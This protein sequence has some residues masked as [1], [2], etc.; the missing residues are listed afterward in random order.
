[1][2]ALL[3]E[4][5]LQLCQQPTTSVS[6][7]D[8]AFAV[9][10]YQYE[11]NA[12]YHRYCSLLGKNPSKITA[13]ADIPFLP[14][15]FFKSQTLMSGDWS[16]QTVFTSSGTTGSTTSQHWVR[17]VHFYK[18]ISALGFAHFYGALEQFCFLGLL[19]SYL[20]RTG[21]SLVVMVDDFVQQSP[22]A[23]SGFFL[24]DH[25]QLATILAKNEVEKVPTVLIGVSF[26]L[27][28]FIEK[29]PMNTPNLIV[30][31][32][33]GM[34]GRRKEMIRPELHEQL[35]AG[36][37]VPH[38]HSEYGMTELF[39]QAYALKEGR[40]QA[41]PTMQIMMR[42]LNDPLSIKASD[43]KLGVINVIDLANIDT[44]SFIATDDLGRAYPNGTF[45]VLGR[46]DHS[47]I[48]GCNL[49][50]A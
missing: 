3:K 30:M 32:T 27:L 7:E 49:M 42:E 24:D 34:K 17:D 9:F 36:F 45:E 2:S 39:S 20:E 23:Q 37:G 26:G 44:C 18:K 41:T 29:H 22:Y 10:E 8:L 1:M 4:K 40:F 43:G 16:S 35:K 47:D 28:D 21:S 33:G 38:I 19:P 50:L 25:A 5:I 13:L 6:F 46:L 14:I 15:Q 12:F 11:H 48:R 31:E